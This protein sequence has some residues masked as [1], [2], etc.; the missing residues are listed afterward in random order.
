M[1]PYTIVW[2]GFRSSGKLGDAEEL[3]R[4]TV[5]MYPDD[6]VAQLRSAIS[7]QQQR[8]DQLDPVYLWARVRVPGTARFAS[9]MLRSLTVRGCPDP[10][11]RLADWLGGDARKTEEEE[12]EDGDG[13]GRGGPI[14]AGAYDLY[15]A[16]KEARDALMPIGGALRLLADEYEYEHVF[17]PPQHLMYASVPSGWLPIVPHTRPWLAL[18]SQALVDWTEAVLP[19]TRMDLG[20]EERCLETLGLVK[21]EVHAIELSSLM[22]AGGQQQVPRAIAALYFSVEPTPPSRIPHPPG[23]TKQRNA[24]ILDALH[25]DSA[26]SHG[27]ATSHDSHGTA[28]PP[29]SRLLELVRLD[30]HGAWSG[31]LDARQ[32]VMASSSSGKP[33]RRGRPGEAG[34]SI[35]DRCAVSATAM[36]DA[37][38]TSQFV[39]HAMLVLSKPVEQRQQH[40]VHK[41]HR[42]VLQTAR[43]RSS[44]MQ[45]GVVLG[46]QLVKT[47]F[48]RAVLQESNHR[49]SEFV[50]A[51]LLGRT[52]RGTVRLYDDS[53]YRF[54]CWF[55]RPHAQAS[56][57]WTEVVELVDGLVL[58]Q[59]LRKL[60]VDPE[61]DDALPAPIAQA[62]VDP[63]THEGGEHIGR[64]AA[65]TNI[66]AVM[67]MSPDRA[68]MAHTSLVVGQSS[69]GGSLVFQTVFFTQDVV[70]AYYVRCSGYVRLGPEQIF[71]AQ[72][73][74]WPKEEVVRQMRERFGP[75]ASG[76]STTPFRPVQ[77]VLQVTLNAR[78][79]RVLLQG[80]SDGRHITRA[81]RA[82][83]WLAVAAKPT[84][85]HELPWTRTEEE[86]QR[87]PL[88]MMNAS[89]LSVL[90]QAEQQDEAAA[91]LQEQQ[92]EQQEMPEEQQQ[93]EQQPDEQQPEQ[94]QGVGEVQKRSSESDVL[95]RIHLADW[96]IF[97][98][99]MAE[100]YVRMC[101]RVDAR[102]PVMVTEEE[103]QDGAMS[104]SSAAV[105]KFNEAFSFGCPEVWCPLSKR[106]YDI[107]KFR[108][109]PQMGENAIQ[110]RSSYWKPGRPRFP[111]YLDPSKHPD[112]VC[113]PCCF[114][115]SS[116]MDC[117][118][119][120]MPLQSSSV[121]RHLL[122][123]QTGPLPLDVLQE[124]F[125][126]GT[127]LRGVEAGSFINCVAF[128]F[129]TSAAELTERL[130]GSTR[131]WFGIGD[132][133]RLGGR[134]VRHFMRDVAMAQ[135]ERTRL[136]RANTLEFRRLVR[137]G[138]PDTSHV[139][140]RLRAVLGQWP[141]RLSPAAQQ[142][143]ELTR[144]W[145]IFLAYRAFVAQVRAGGK[146]L[147]HDLLMQ[148]L[149]SPRV[150]RHCSG[151]G[152]SADRGVW[153]YVLQ[154]GGGGGS[155]DDD[156]DLHEERAG[157]SV[158]HACL[159]GGAFRRP[160]T[161]QRCSFIWRR[162][163]LHYEV[164]VL[165]PPRGKVN[166]RPPQDRSG[167]QGKGGGRYRS[168]FATEEVRHLVRTLDVAC[169]AHRGGMDP[170]SLVW[171][172][173]MHRMDRVSVRGLVYDYDF[174]CHGAVVALPQ[175][176]G[177]RGDAALLYVPLPR[178]V[179]GTA[180]PED[181]DGGGG[182]QLL[183][184]VFVSDLLRCA[185]GVDVHDATAFFAQLEVFTGQDAYR[186]QG[187]FVRQGRA[188]ALK[189]HSGA[190][191]PLEHAHG[192]D[193][194]EYDELTSHFSDNLNI[195]VASQDLDD[196][197]TRL[198]TNLQAHAE[199]RATL[200]LV[201]SKLLEGSAAGSY[202]L[203]SHQKS[204]LLSR[205]YR[206]WVHPLNPYPHHHKHA[207]LV[208]LVSSIVRQH[209]PTWCRS[210]E[211]C[212]DELARDL[213]LPLSC[214]S[215]A[216]A[217]TFPPRSCRMTERDYTPEETPDDIEAVFDHATEAIRD[218]AGIRS[219]GR[220]TTIHWTSLASSLGPQ[221]YVVATRTP[222]LDLWF[223]E[224]GHTRVLSGEGGQEEGF[225]ALLSVG[226]EASRKLL[227]DAV[228]ASS[229]VDGK[230]LSKP[231]R[232]E[233]TMEEAG[234]LAGAMKVSVLLL[235]PPRRFVLMKAVG[236][237]R[238][239]VFVWSD[240]GGVPVEQPQ[241]LELV[242]ARQQQPWSS[243]DSP[244]AE[245][246]L[247]VPT[248]AFGLSFALRVVLP[249][250]LHN[251]LEE[252]IKRQLPPAAAP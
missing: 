226:P 210:V 249:F 151:L 78:N 25:L 62:V 250:V 46:V 212:A 73:A 127:Q 186:V 5:S 200:A 51:T 244:S 79:G 138:A 172:V 139:A 167:G 84:P 239:V 229:P 61:C 121:S 57:A 10:G 211:E 9:H 185:A 111:G 251:N 115:K 231:V 242:I 175:H 66:S 245:S 34:W 217:T 236:S 36:F 194:D 94:Q 69:S 97:D 158:E 233:L 181:V 39:P 82:L 224:Q 160:V 213:M 203:R 240:R 32:L 90:L 107:K 206:F 6:T 168:V 109:C 169:M 174:L 44:S 170:T 180:L 12:E 252:S 110:F 189:L 234:L 104:N 106:A 126:P 19:A 28:L 64:A 93:D 133:V 103:L 76:A 214:L 80:A 222:M 56:R 131:P 95:R 72:R 75:E 171:R 195:L 26:T 164:F 123:N 155:E 122:Q 179:P 130:V 2:H 208:A 241:Q 144:D 148:L 141:E 176:G 23:R 247:L 182:G 43:A 52:V 96:R 153:M 54:R 17:I 99:R 248:W 98:R 100:S 173:L 117:V 197:S 47:G 83:C 22:M 129:E 87:Q 102:Q 184:V 145:L 146:P 140:P 74:H 89:D 65:F 31:G 1:Q 156:G 142:H 86:V 223:L 35:P 216:F 238:C 125:P 209:L 215:P 243:S 159:S 162:H 134:V 68:R 70:R 4:T 221:Q 58:G 188:V 49:S 114:R 29:E 77:G 53:R 55:P 183:P 218:F 60:P 92:D 220:G 48:Q 163:G 150:Q 81:A 59:L 113:M 137:S 50:E 14:S 219:F 132:F 230:R 207:Q 187:A 8:R 42:S 235:V 198:V 193:H 205:A 232:G 196:A 191:V 165:P 177:R 38:R 135:G 41:L 21:P 27:S 3:A 128:I 37:L 63:L 178:A 190:V 7:Q 33:R 192:G 166:E 116:R 101:G 143:R 91:D 161:A 118:Q 71:M 40:V 11:G 124:V 119:S 20:Q 15:H 147:P 246:G 149:N 136:T 157:E 85:E 204:S 237:D 227:Y 88:E 112:G 108:G 202:D 228:R 67:T 24:A 16:V 45:G 105:I 18:K 201:R 152:L 225:L 13:G 120:P 154:P 199:R 30:G